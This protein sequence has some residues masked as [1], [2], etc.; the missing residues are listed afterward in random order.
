MADFRCRN[1]S[2]AINALKINSTVTK[3]YLSW[4]QINNEGAIALGE[5]LKINSTVTK[6]YLS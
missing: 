2:E 6:L 1:L 5:A 4:N 3:L